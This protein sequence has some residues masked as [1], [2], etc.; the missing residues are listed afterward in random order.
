MIAI[1]G[2][3]GLTAE[4]VA[5]PAG[6]Q[7]R[8]P[9]GLLQQ[10]L[11][12]PVLEQPALKQRFVLRLVAHVTGGMTAPH[13]RAHLPGTRSDPNGARRPIAGRPVVS[14]LAFDTSRVMNALGLCPHATSNP[15]S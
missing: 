12:I 3:V 5:P 8:L 6:D 2:S 15:N 7:P 13:T 4:S 1:V 9:A 10:D 11:A 14:N